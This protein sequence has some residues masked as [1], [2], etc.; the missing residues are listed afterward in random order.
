MAGFRHE[1][2]EASGAVHGCVQAT[3]SPLETLQRDGLR[4]TP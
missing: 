3:Y 4:K 1:I 2:A